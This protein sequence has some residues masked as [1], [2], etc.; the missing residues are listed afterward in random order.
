MTVGQRKSRG[1]RNALYR[2]RADSRVL[3][4]AREEGRASKEN[5]LIAAAN[6][7]EPAKASLCSE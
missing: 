7:A 4:R 6:R 3:S 1:A 2:Q 5:A